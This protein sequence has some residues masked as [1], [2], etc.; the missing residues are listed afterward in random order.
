MSEQRSDNLSHLCEAFPFLRV[1]PYPLFV[2]L[3]LS[4]LWWPSAGLIQTCVQLEQLLR[5]YVITYRSKVGKLPQ[6]GT[7]HLCRVLVPAQLSSQQLAWLEQAEQAIR[8]LEVHLV[9]YHKP[10][11]LRNEQVR[12]LLA[13]PEELWL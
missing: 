11:Q 10:L 4:E 2:H 8:P 13:T 3:D 6:P 12:K 9:A 5:A 7:Y 1:L